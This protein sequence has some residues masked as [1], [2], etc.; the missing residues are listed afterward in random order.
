MHKTE[1]DFFYFIFIISDNHLR[2]VVDYLFTHHGLSCG[3]ILLLLQ[4]E[5]IHEVQPDQMGQI[6]FNGSWVEVL[7]QTW[8]TTPSTVRRTE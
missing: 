1:R 2:E 3:H 5:E 8:T 7:Y 4:C 6:L